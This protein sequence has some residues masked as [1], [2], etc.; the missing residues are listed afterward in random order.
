MAQSVK[1]PS[2]DSGSHG[3]LSSVLDLRVMSLSSKQGSMLSMEPT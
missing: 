2:L 3:D 1:H